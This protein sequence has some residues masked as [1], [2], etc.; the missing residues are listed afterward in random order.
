VDKVLRVIVALPG[1]FFGLTGLQWIVNPTQAAA[2]LGVTLPEG[3]A[4][5][6]IVGDLGAF[7]LCLSAMILV[8]VATLQRG[9]LI[10]ASLFMVTA[11]SMR[12]LAWAVHDADF[13][14]AFISVELVVAAVLF[15]GGNKITAAR[16]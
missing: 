5:S 12:L 9:W 7:F 1:V 2:G 6:T 3:I 11:A 15:F 10:A 13:A 14:A 4:R 8:G 16:E